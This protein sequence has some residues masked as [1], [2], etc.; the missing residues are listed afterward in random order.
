MAIPAPLSIKSTA[1]GNSQHGGALFTLPRE[2]RD[3]IYRL[4]VKKRYIIYITPHEDNH[5]TT[6]KHD[7]A[8]LEVSQAVSSEAL[9]ILYSEAVFCF[10][11]DFR[12]DDYPRRPSQLTNRIKNVEFNIIGLGICPA[13][14][15][16]QTPCLR[17]LDHPDI[18][19]HSAMAKFTD[20][21]IAGNSVRIRLLLCD[22]D[23]IEDLFVSTFET[24]KV[25]MGFRTIT[26]EVVPIS[27]SSRELG[28]SKREQW[29]FP[30]LSKEHDSQI[31]QEVKS[32]LEPT[33]GPA[34]EE[35]HGDVQ[36]LTFHPGK[37]AIKSTKED[38]K[39]LI[40]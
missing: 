38:G 27:V 30:W 8:I 16:S 3:E 23:S 39:H 33:L 22:P 29:V 17:H 2:L 5:V 1:L 40:F 25:F 18:F 19:Y 10:S 13:L 20:A 37:N 36:H 6:E 28:M 15:S 7:L 24:L 21:E 35:Y 32:S 12:S 9:E 31:G 14:C 11:V 26:I 4:L 34:A